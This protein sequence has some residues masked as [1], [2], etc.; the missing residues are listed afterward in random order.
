MVIDL[1]GKSSMADF[2]V[3]ASGTSQ[4]H[5][6]AMADHLLQKIKAMNGA[7]ASIEGATQCDWVLI[8]AGDL[9]V[10]LFRP[11]VRSFYA[12]ERLWGAD[13]APRARQ[14]EMAAGRF[15]A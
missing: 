7:S 2:M 3:I 1:S 9:I 12:L 6:G 13:S 11:E 10:H 15:S 4:R 5:I 14:A 8:D